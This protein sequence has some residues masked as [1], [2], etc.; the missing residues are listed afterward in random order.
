M[1]DDT[2][3]VK[4]FNL[5][6]HHDEVG[7]PVFAGHFSKVTFA[8]PEIW[9]GAQFLS[10]RFGL[11]DVNGKSA[12]VWFDQ[13]V[14]FFVCKAL[15]K[16]MERDFGTELY[17]C[18]PAVVCEFPQFHFYTFYQAF[19]VL[20]GAARSA[21]VPFGT[22]LHLNSCSDLSENAIAQHSRK[23]Q[24]WMNLQGLGASDE[25]VL[26]P[27]NRVAIDKWYAHEFPK[28]SGWELDWE[29]W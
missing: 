20:S 19:S 25:Y 22:E 18:G 10:K 17:I 12:L 29:Q 27:R 14:P 11:Q 24:Q 9:K 6:L 13:H 2:L 15:L 21:L 1:H 26:C 4:P 23:S 28:K 7:R 8:A 16:Q 5:M 3:L